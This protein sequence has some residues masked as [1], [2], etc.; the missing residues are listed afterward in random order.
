MS[1][2]IPEVEL[3]AEGREAVEE[4]DDRTMNPGLRCVPNSAPL[5][6][7]DPD[8]KRIEVSEE[9][10]VIESASGMARREI[11]MSADDHEGALS[12]VQG[13]SIG[14]WEDDTLVIETRRFVDHSMGNGYAGIPSGPR[15]HLIERLAL[16]EDGKS[17]TYAFELR[18]P[19][20]LAQ[21]VAAE[22][23][24]AHRPDLILSTAEC[25]L[26]NAR[27]FRN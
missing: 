25:S 2:V 8:V 22:V 3:T 11:H 10:I 19:D 14:R 6:M 21:P 23:T 24:W 18:D 26:D 17:L 7:I 27:R 13:H 20:F 4:F 5:L 9:L 12:S 1:L 16:D 15:K